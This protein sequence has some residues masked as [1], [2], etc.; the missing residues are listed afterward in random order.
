MSRT[1]NDPTAALSFRKLMALE[2]VDISSEGRSYAI[3]TFRSIVPAWASGGKTAF[4]EHVFAQAAW[5]ASRTVGRGM[6][7][8]VWLVQHGDYH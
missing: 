5:A 4:G 3:K 1:D 6:I 2:D 7:I 8:R